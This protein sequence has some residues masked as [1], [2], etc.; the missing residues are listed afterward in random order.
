MLSRSLNDVTGGL[1]DVR[2]VWVTQTFKFVHNVREQGSRLLAFQREIAT[3]L[4]GLEDTSQINI[5]H[6]LKN[7]RHF[8]FKQ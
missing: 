3:H 1:T 4:S 8:A 7:R 6:V 2:L 5:K